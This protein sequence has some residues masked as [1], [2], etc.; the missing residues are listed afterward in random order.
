MR[1]ILLLTIILSFSVIVACDANNE[2]LGTLTGKVTIGPLAPVV[3]E[4]QA[5]PT[6]GPEVYAGREIVVFDE[7]GE[8]EISRAAIS[9]DG[10]YRISLA[11]GDY[12]VDINHIGIDIAKG[13]PTTVTIVGGRETRLDVDIDTGIR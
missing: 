5:E 3:Q 10:A 1:F 6:P 9:P 12:V 4:D 11:P 8:R 13:L 7:S 2:P